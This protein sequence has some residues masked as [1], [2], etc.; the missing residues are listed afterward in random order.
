MPESGVGPGGLCQG[1]VGP[2]EVAVLLGWF[3]GRSVMKMKWLTGVW[4]LLSCPRSA[5]PLPTAPSLEGGW[6][7]VTRLGLCLG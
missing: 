3:V 7:P 6:D 4:G 2:Q 5:W 1:S